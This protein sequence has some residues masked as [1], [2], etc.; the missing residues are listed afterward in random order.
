MNESQQKIFR[1]HLFRLP[2][3]MLEYMNLLTDFSQMLTDANKC[4]LK[5]VSAN[6][7]K[8]K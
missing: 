2:I 4:I 8:T 6:E 3:G 1:Q 5:K 7:K